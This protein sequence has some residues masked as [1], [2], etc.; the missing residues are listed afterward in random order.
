MNKLTIRI[1][2]GAGD[3]PREDWSALCE[4]GHPFLNGDFLRIVEERGV[5]APDAGWQPLHLVASEDGAIVGILPLYLKG[6]S[7]GDFIYD[8]SWKPVWDRFGHRYY[9]RLIS[10]LPYTPVA[11]PRLLIAPRVV[12]RS[13]V[14]DAL[15][16]A[17]QGICAENGFSTWHVALATTADI[18]A[19]AASGLLVS[20]DVQYHWSDAG[21]GDFDGFLQS[22]SAEKRRKVRAERRRAAGSGL[23]I[24][25]RH[26]DEVGGHEWPGLHRL[27]KSTFDRFGNFAAFSPECFAEL[28]TTLGDRMVLF[29]A[30]DGD[31][32]VALSL[33]FR[34]HDTLFGRYWGASRH[35]DSLHFE[36]C[37]YR[38]IDYCLSHGLTRFEPGAG[39]EHKLARGFT[40]QIVRSAH[41]I[42]N[43]QMRRVIA[44]HLQRQKLDVAAWQDDA[45]NHL[46]FRKPDAGVR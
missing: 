30:H 32:T 21:F 11:G 15:I 33:C 34:S 10:G 46:P 12:D 28:A 1:A 24:D 41:W 18:D 20:H 31:E 16:A 27:Y 35:V 5:A 17:A 23:R 42:A 3:I 26:G 9:P 4:P 45:R 6:H 19:V 14:R 29:T 13:V 44:P 2:H 8:W 39:G 22:F 38:G 40:P 37:F 7:H 43:P 36:L 25:V